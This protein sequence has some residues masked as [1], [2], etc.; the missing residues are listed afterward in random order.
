MSKLTENYFT[1]FLE[2]RGYK[3]Y[4]NKFTKGFV[5][6]TMM[7]N[8]KR[9]WMEDK[10]PRHKYPHI[11]TSLSPTNLQEAEILFKLLEIERKEIGTKNWKKLKKNEC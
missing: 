10:N 4:D 5:I 8:Y 11:V 9:C 7:G 1:S 6:V 3:R 2:E